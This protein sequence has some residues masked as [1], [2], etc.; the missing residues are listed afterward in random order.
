MVEGRI[1]PWEFAHSYTYGGADLNDNVQELTE[2]IFLPM[3][4]E[5]RRYLE[6]Q[7]ISKRPV[8]VAP[9]GVS[10]PASDRVVRLDH[11]SVAYIEVIDALDK[12]ERTLKEANDYPDLEEKEQ[13][14]AEISAGRR[15][16]TAV[17]VRI[18]V[19]VAVLSGPLTYLA[20]KF[21]DTGISTA[22]K[23]AWE[24]LTVLFGMIF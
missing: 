23:T 8:S 9:P 10:A 20:K 13:H 4:R 3:A 19:I 12:L 21:I 14:V 7:I 18:G 16:L 22:A 1:E 2:Q 11:N 24:K 6:T 15:L 17:R 5:L